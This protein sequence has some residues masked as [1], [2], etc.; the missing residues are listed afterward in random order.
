[1]GS[2]SL[3][4]KQDYPP[5]ID[6]SDYEHLPLPASWDWRQYKIVGP[7]KDQHVNNSKCGCCCACHSII[8]LMAVHTPPQG[9]LQPLRLLKWST[10]SILGRYAD[11]TSCA[12][13]CEW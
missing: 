1:M 4:S 9:R 7:V 13:K 8:L 6:P 12:I 5:F 10:H 2:T 3:H 11:N